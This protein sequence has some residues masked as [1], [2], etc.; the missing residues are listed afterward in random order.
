MRRT[1]QNISKTDRA[2][3]HATL[4]R[5]GERTENLPLDQRF[6]RKFDRKDH[7]VDVERADMQRRNWRNDNRWNSRGTER[8]QQQQQQQQEVRHPSPETWRKPVEQP[9]PASA[10]GVGPRYGKVASAVELAQAFSRSFSDPKLGD[11][12][13]GQRGLP[14]RSQMPFSRLTGPTSRPQINGY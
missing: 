5:Q 9:K 8:E 1:K 10:D 6:G 7:R 12:Y 14:G 4:A 13:S 2:I 3:E 11:R